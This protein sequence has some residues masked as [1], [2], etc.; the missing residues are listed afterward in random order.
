VALAVDVEMV[1]ES[2]GY[3]PTTPT[4]IEE[5]YSRDGLYNPGDDVRAFLLLLRAQHGPHR[6]VHRW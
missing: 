4:G 2:P 6:Y 1:L 5:G 3:L